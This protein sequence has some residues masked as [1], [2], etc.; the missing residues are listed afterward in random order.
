MVNVV[1]N[2]NESEG[3]ER[4]SRPPEA[5][6]AE[7]CRRNAI[8]VRSEKKNAELKIRLT[9]HRILIEIEPKLDSHEHTG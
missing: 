2:G 6:K 1:R 4:E 3:R 7:T 5:M 8:R 9:Q